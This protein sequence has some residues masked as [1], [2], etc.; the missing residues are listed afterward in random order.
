[1]DKSP[2]R[3]LIVDDEENFA[4]SLRLYLQM[5][6]YAA[7][8]AKGAEQA[9]EAAAEKKYDLI[10]SDIFMPHMDGYELRKNLRSR[11]NTARTPIILLTAKE[12]DVETLKQIHDG[13]T[14]FIMKPF[15]HSLLLEEIGNLLERTGKTR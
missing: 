7:D 14:S 1:M 9:L 2:K 12:A 15:D 8:T 11:E 4:K 6:D 5:E 13:I 3:I 10:I